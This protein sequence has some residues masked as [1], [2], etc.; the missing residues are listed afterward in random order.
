MSTKTWSEKQAADA[1]KRAKAHWGG[2][3]ANLS[4]DMKEAYIAREVVRVLVGQDEDTASQAMKRMIE[5]AD[6]ALADENFRKG[7]PA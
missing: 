4:E 1:I 2:G 7:P 5:F 3:W 6:L